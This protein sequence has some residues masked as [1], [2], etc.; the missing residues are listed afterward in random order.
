MKK[1]TNKQ[2]KGGNRSNEFDFYTSE[3]G[4]AIIA[5]SKRDGL[6]NDEV[7]KKIGITR[8]TLYEWRSKSVALSDTLKISKDMADATLENKAFQMAME[9][10]T[11]MM[12]FLLKNRMSS[13]YKDRQEMGLDVA[14]EEVIESVGLLVDKFK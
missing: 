5:Q 12:I 9:G 13:K 1:E 6:T 2:H 7:A 14:K 3:E 10:N 4:L 11:T 8:S